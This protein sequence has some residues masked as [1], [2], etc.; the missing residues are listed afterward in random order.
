MI[1][2]VADYEEKKLLS[3]LKIK[4]IVNEGREVA[5]ALIKEALG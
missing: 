2:R 5:K 4:H 3:D 1:V